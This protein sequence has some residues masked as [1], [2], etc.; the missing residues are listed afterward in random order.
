L[1]GDQGV[2]VA[3][4]VLRVLALTRDSSG[5]FLGISS[6]KDLVD[7]VSVGIGFRCKLSKHQK[8]DHCSTTI[9]PTTTDSPVRLTYSRQ[10]LLIWNHVLYIT[11]ENECG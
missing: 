7:G 5:G 6:A 9:E 4:V 3:V 10:S 11:V 8:V 1:R 2:E